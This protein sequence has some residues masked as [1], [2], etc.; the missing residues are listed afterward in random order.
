MF[1][2]NTFEN[3]Q[4]QPIT[5]ARSNRNHLNLSLNFSNEIE[6]EQTAPP[7]IE[8]NFNYSLRDMINFANNNQ[9]PKK[10]FIINNVKRGYTATL[11]FFDCVTTFNEF[12]KYRI[13]FKCRGC[14]TQFEQLL[15]NT[16]YLNRHLRSYCKSNEVRFWY[17]KVREFSNKND[18]SILS[19]DKLLLV[20]FF[21]SS[22]AS[23]VTLL[24]PYLRELIKMKIPMPG[25]FT[26]R[27]T[28]L[29]EVLN[30]LYMLIENKLET[31]VTVC[32][33]VDLWT[34]LI[35]SDYIALGVVITN[36][37]FDRE[38]IIVNM[39]RMIGTHNSENVKLAI[40]TL[41]N[42]FRFDKSKIHSIFLI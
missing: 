17:T 35:N 7:I 2:Q 39:M 27:H 18:V 25:F 12:P 9:F 20:K 31:A 6:A 23:L 21:I 28:I 5:S 16:T 36:N 4:S 34:N 41:I 30:H 3:S 8:Q 32:F 24:N 40:E 13:E 19:D 11:N 10:T 14:G 38:M 33:V 1:Q 37:S 42:R 29:P 22:N 15:A 26:F